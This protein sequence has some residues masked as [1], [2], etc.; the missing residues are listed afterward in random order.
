MQLIISRDVLLNAINLISKA[1]DKRHNIAIL[2]NIKLVLSQTKLELTASDL[3]VELQATLNLPEG[4]CQEAGQ[5]TVPANKFKDIIKL[6][7]DSLVSI[8]VDTDQQCH[9]VCGKSH[10]KLGTLPAKDFPLLGQPEHVTPIQLGR[11]IL[12]DLLEKTHFAIA[13]QDV[14]HYLTGML[15][16]LNENQLHLVATDGHRLALAR[17]LIENSD[18]AEL[19]AILPRKA[20]LELQR[21]LVELKKLLP[22]HDNIITLH[23]GREFLQV[24]LPFGEVGDDGQ[25]KNPILVTFTS[26]LIEGKFPDYRRVIPA[27][28]DKL[29]VINIDQLS[30]VLRRVSVLSHEKSRGVIFNFNDA[31][32]LELIANNSEHDEAREQ[33][34]IK[35][36]GEAL[37]ISFNVSYLLDVLNKLQG[38]VEFHMSQANGSVL[39]RQINDS[40]HDFVVMPIRL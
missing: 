14:R 30:D 19:T 22:N 12:S 32:S 21:L 25:I 1:S 26:R 34:T 31:E 17:T 28:T 6:L 11:E 16:E 3:E 7:P 18:N 20:V 8:S 4:A 5:I 2:A 40:F 29:A 13:I 27:N 38:N 15:F 35:Y 33:L 36:Q 37:E 23:V 39:V 10:F 9:I 24:I